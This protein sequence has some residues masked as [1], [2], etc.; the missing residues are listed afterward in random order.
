MFQCFTIEVKCLRTYSLEKNVVFLQF[1]VLHLL[2]VKLHPYPEQVLEPIG[3]P[4]IAA[5]RMVGVFGYRCNLTL[6]LPD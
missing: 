3:Q 5:A 4:S 2:R 6:R 1:H